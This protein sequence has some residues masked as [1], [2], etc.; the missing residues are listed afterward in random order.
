[1]Q[2]EYIIMYNANKNIFVYKQQIM[3]LSPWI[4]NNKHSSQ[5]GHEILELIIH[6]RK[7][8]SFE[9]YIH[10]RYQENWVRTSNETYSFRS[11]WWEVNIG[12]DNG[13]VSDGTKPL[14]KL[15]LTK[16]TDTL[17]NL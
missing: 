17:L 5:K 8:L 4:N 1:M 10:Y 12:S 2:N 14:P 16:I 15:M 3:K 9:K 6:Q 11:K 7:W 13:L